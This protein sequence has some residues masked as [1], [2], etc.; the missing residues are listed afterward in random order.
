[1]SVNQTFSSKPN[2]LFLLAT[3]TLEALYAELDGLVERTTQADFSALSF[4]ASEW[5]SSYAYSSADFRL[6]ILV[7]TR[8]ELRDRIIKL[9]EYLGHSPLDIGDWI[10]FES[11]IM[12]GRAVEPVKVGFLFPGQGSQQHNASAHWLCRYEWGRDL[13][14]LVESTLEE[15]GFPS[16][17]SVLFDAG[18]EASAKGLETEFQEGVALK[19][20]HHALYAQLATVLTSLLAAEFLHRLGIYPSVVVGHSV[21]ELSALAEAGAIE[22]DTL[23]RLVAERARSMAEREENGDRAGSMLSLLCSEAEAINIVDQISGYLTVACVNGEH[24]VVLSGEAQSIQ[25]AIEMAKTQGIK[26]S[27]LF[28]EN[29][30]HSRLMAHTAEKLR[31]FEWLN[32]EASAISIPMISAMDGSIRYGHIDLNEYCAAQVT[33][34]VRFLDVIRTLGEQC[35]VAIEVGSG[36]TLTALMTEYYAFNELPTLA[37]QSVPGTNNDL[38]HIVGLLFAMGHTIHAELLYPE[39][40]QEQD[41]Q[42]EDERDNTH[43]DVA[44]ISDAPLEMEAFKTLLGLTEVSKSEFLSYMQR[45]GHFIG[46]VIAADM[47]H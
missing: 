28:V 40:V 24:Q 43:E 15:Y 29:A 4:L 37:I 47:K 1:M 26:Y 45:R 25:D 9:K 41:E 36:R 11:G 39:S 46:Q 17:S 44:P 13:L 7:A 16:L 2:I 35:D 27:P 5:N 14:D 23:I 10:Q 8:D 3:D 32:Q 34:P 38:H 42:S 22:I 12:L 19:P 30:F 31:S 21:G 6:A 33:A 18:T 20:L